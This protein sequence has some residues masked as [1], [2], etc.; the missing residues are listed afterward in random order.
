MRS[1]HSS[2]R[3]CDWGLVGLDPDRL[4]ADARIRGRRPEN[5][6]HHDSDGS[7]HAARGRARDYKRANEILLSASTVLRP[8]ARSATAVLSYLDAA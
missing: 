2:R 7:D 6:G 3:W 8:R 1:C 4:P 5:A